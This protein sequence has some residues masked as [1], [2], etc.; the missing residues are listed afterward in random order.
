MVVGGIPLKVTASVN[1]CATP[2][3]VTFAVRNDQFLENAFYEDGRDNGSHLI[4]RQSSAEKVSWEYTFVTSNQPESRRIPG[5]D[6]VAGGAGG[7][8]D[9]HSVLFH[10]QADSSRMRHSLGKVI[11]VRAQF[12]VNGQTDES[13]TFLDG[14]EVKVAHF[15]DCAGSRHHSEV[16]YI[17]LGNDNSDKNNNRGSGA[18]EAT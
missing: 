13:L 1:H 11:D 3:D 2:I 12:I 14:A 7:D 5:Y 6:L 15:D 4:P 9:R 8:A 10:M 16:N 17:A 18:V